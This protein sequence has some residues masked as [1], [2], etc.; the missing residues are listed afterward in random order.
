MTLIERIRLAWEEFWIMV[1]ACIV[2]I[3]PEEEK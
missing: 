1:L 2:D 3:D